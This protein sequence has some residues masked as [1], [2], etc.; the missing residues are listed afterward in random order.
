M[1]YRDGFADL[2]FIL[3]LALSLFAVV[4][5][6][7]EPF[8]W[9]T[10]RAMVAALFH[11]GHSTVILDACNNTHKRRDEW[12]SMEW[13]IIFKV[14]NTPAEIR[15]ERARGEGDQQIIQVIERMAAEHESLGEEEIQWP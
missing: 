9:A 3:Q 1:I 12:R 8:V 5:D 4:V 10:A 7:A 14:I 15:I 11:A 13:D 2:P 6:E